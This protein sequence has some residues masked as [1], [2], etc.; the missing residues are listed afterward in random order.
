MIDVKAHQDRER[1]RE[2]REEHADEL[3]CM[4]EAEQAKAI[5]QYIDDCKNE[6][7]AKLEAECLAKHKTAPSMTTFTALMHARMR[8][9]LV[10]VIA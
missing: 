1:E 7:W 3:A 10:Q 5:Q 8:G 4:S 9:K 6:Y 2:F